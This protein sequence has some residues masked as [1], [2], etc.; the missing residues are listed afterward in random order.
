MHASIAED[1]RP[2]KRAYRARL[3]FMRESCQG[4]ESFWRV[5]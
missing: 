5:A 1:L 2:A 3:R 4:N